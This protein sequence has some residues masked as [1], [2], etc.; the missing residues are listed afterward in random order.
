MRSEEGFTLVETLVVAL[1]LPIVLG[2][3]LMALDT[4]ARVTPKSMEYSSAVQESGDGASR[5]MRELRQ[6]YRIVGT[7]PNSIT[8][9]AVLGGVDQQIAISCDVPYPAAAG[10]PYAAG[11]RRCVRV[12]APVGQPLPDVSAGRVEVDRLLNGTLAAPVFTYS[13]SPIMPTYVR[14]SFQV[15]ARGERADGQSHTISIDNGTRLRN[16]DLGA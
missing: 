7:T 5:I 16:N 14:A 11:Y 4:A 2:A 6:A 10:N 15:A 3:I 8:F 9:L 1:V 13:P 12:G